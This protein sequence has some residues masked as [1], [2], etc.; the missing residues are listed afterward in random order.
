MHKPKARCRASAFPVDRDVCFIPS[1]PVC[2][3]VDAVPLHSSRASQRMMSS[4]FD[5]H[6]YHCRC[7]CDSLVLEPSCWRPCRHAPR[8]RCWLTDPPPPL[9]WRICGDDRRSGSRHWNT[10]DHRRYR[11]PASNSHSQFILSRPT[12]SI[13]QSI[14]KVLKWPK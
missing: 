10:I 13:N 5:V 1:L 7:R 14:W 11:P 6:R 2:Q 12:S 9:Y 3:L 4:T 8:S